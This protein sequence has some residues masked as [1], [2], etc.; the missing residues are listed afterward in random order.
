MTTEHKILTLIDRGV[1]SI[2]DLE[3]L[4]GSRKWISDAIWRLVFRG[5]AY[6]LDHCS[7][8]LALTSEGLDRLNALDEKEAA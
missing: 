1:S 6:Q 4:F 3:R 7:G 2:D 8:S 5:C